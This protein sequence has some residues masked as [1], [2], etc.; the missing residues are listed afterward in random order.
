[1]PEYLAPGVYVE[2]TS[3]RAKSIQGVSTSTAGFIG[4]TRTGP[5]TG[6]PEL[7][8]SFADFERIY[9]GFTDLAFSNGARPNY[10]A[11]AVRAFFEEG[12]R[13]LYVMRVF[14]AA[15]SETVTDFGIGDD[16]IPANHYAT[17]IR[18]DDV[19]TDPTP[20]LVTLVA[21]FPG[22]AGNMRVT[23]SL[24]VGAN[25]LQ[26]GGAIPALSRVRNFD[27]VLARVPSGGTPPYT[28]HGSADGLLIATR[29]AVTG[30]WTLSDSLVEPD[31]SVVLDGSGPLPAGLEVRV[32][33]VTV[34]IQRPGE[35]PLT[36]ESPQ[37]LGEFSFD[38][39]STGAL[40]TT[41]AANPATRFQA[42]TIPFALDRIQNTSEDAIPDDQ[43]GL[44]LIRQLFG[45]TRVG[46]LLAAENPSVSANFTLSG[47]SDGA[48][49]TS[50]QYD[51]DDSGLVDYQNDAIQAPKNG[52]LAFEDVENISI[53]AATGYTDYGNEAA[54]FAIQN[55][56]INHCERMFYRVAVLDTPR[57][58]LVS[59]AL[60]YRNLRSSTHAA[61][62]Y[63]WIRVIDPRPSRGGQ[64]ML[65]PPS[66]H[67]AGMYARNDNEAAVFKAPANMVVR[68][69]VGFEQ[70]LNKAH[71]EVLNPQGVNVFR[72][73]E[74]RG[75]LLW[76]ART[77]SD[78]SDWTYVSVR[79]YFA[80]MEYSI[81]RGTQWAVFENNGPELWANVRRTVENFLFNEW[82][83]GGLLGDKAEDAY[84]VICDRSTMTQQDLDQGRLVCLIGVAPVKPAEFVIFRIGQFTADSNQ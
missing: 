10:L 30:I 65:V 57:N 3:F 40:T 33:T 72:F 55:S 80:Y 29:D 51:G 18:R 59:Q 60:N 36:F 43:V 73:F 38:A 70:V 62:Y 23:L 22:E 76:G 75:Y 41:F 63:P 81:D 67:V 56:I 49:P 47:G 52:L 68:T 5:L 66:G 16:G 31:V 8:T 32:V 84:F 21:R 79:R 11:H 35:R 1:M 28:A 39:R 50:V 37:F 74:G 24:R 71:Q 6:E 54:A 26:T 46:E 34:E 82:R 78:D 17:A 42:L 69:A 53:V 15:T 44:H 48:I 27:L 19:T 77:I 9:G 7:L 2:E 12:G 45:G 20:P 4:P 58:Y 64:P 25:V 61:I 83:A 14:N 13:R